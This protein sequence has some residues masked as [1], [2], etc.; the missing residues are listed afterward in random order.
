MASDYFK[1]IIQYFKIKYIYS[2]QDGNKDISSLNKSS[3]TKGGNNIDPKS[4]GETKDLSRAPKLCKVEYE[5][6]WSYPSG[7]A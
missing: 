6:R 7:G 4:D 5:R 1:F 2:I 3:Y